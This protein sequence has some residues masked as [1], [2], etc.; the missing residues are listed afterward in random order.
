VSER[1]PDAI[2]P[3]GEQGEGDVDAR[4]LVWNGRVTAPVPVRREGQDR[5]D[6]GGSPSEDEAATRERP[7]PG[8]SSVS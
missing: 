4:I 7:S 8:L 3:R 5:R 1:R 2:R 6:H